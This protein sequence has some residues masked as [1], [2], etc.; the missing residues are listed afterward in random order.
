MGNATAE[1]GVGLRP[2]PPFVGDHPAMDFLNSRAVPGGV[3]LEWLADGPDLRAWLA[4]AGMPVPAGLRPA[5]W[6]AAAGHAKA[7][8]ETF[9]AFVDRH[10]GRPLTAGAA[11]ELRAVNDLLAADDTYRQVEPGT[12]DEPLVWRRHRR[13]AAA[14]EPLL[15]IADALGDLVTTADFTL[16]RRCEGVGCTLAFLDRTKSHARRWCDMA[17]C[18]NRAKAA[19]HRARGRA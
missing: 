13:P 11:R 17:V 6:D 5:A 3:E 7:L 2:P 12:G 18:G 16:V 14:A 10:A 15:P 9:R 19:A 8:R 4:A 1:G